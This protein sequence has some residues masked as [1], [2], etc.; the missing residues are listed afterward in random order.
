MEILTVDEVSKALKLPRETIRK[1]LREGILE[2]SRIG[3]NWRIKRQALESFMNDNSNRK[4]D[5]DGE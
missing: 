1:Y 5:V 4:A 2:G 3:K